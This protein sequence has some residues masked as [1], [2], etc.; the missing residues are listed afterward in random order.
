MSM[1]ATDAGSRYL[2]KAGNLDAACEWL[3]SEGEFAHKVG[4]V[5]DCVVLSANGCEDM[6]CGSVC[7]GI[8][9][10]IEEFLERFCEPGSYACQRVDDFFQY[11]L[12]WKDADG[13]HSEGREYV[14]PF[15][16]KIAELEG[17][18]ESC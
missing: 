5:R 15:A 18:E 9:K 8:G 6:F 14:N 16:G 11:D 4:V 3:E 10:C 7:Y 13:V 17:Q 1:Y 12:Y 2:V